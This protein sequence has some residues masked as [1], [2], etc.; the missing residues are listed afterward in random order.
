MHAYKDNQQAVL[1]DGLTDLTDVGPHFV[2]GE[3]VG[4][5]VTQLL[6]VLAA[7]Q[8]EVW[9]DAVVVQHVHHQVVLRRVRLVAQLTLPPLLF[10]VRD[11][12]RVIDADADLHTEGRVG[13][14][15]GGRVGRFS[16]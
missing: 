16:L 14:G 8:A 4:V 12:L 2:V 15:G 13:W 9:F 3:H 6:E 11:A 7:D 5:E 1:S 10:P